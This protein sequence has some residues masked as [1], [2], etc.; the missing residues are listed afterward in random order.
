MKKKYLAF[1]CTIAC[2]FGLTACG[3]DSTLTEYEQSKVDDAKAIASETYV[4]M[5]AYYCLTNDYSSM[6]DDYTTDEIEYMFSEN[7]NLNVEGY[8]FQKAIDS[9]TSAAE[10]IGEYEGIG[11]VTAEI[12]DDQ[13]VVDV[14]VFGSEKDA[15]A[16]IIVSN[17][18]FY[19]L[20]SAALNPV[21]TMSEMMLNAALN[22]LIGMG[23]V[24]IILILISCLISAFSFI[25]KIQ[26]KL[27]AGKNEKKEQPKSGI[28]NAVAQITAQE[29][30]VSAADDL[31]I[32]AV[33]AAAVAAARGES[34][35]DGF[36]VRSIR[37][38]F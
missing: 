25:P 31:E 35:T 15:K 33:I 11:E 21:E 34:S 4:P 37:K 23:T 36:V 28:D 7:F 26:A 22:T 1:A 2:V 17:D 10:D 32:V 18:M 16:E 14:E 12:D 19:K 3:S 30:A 29:Q 13:I 8:A 9:F 27:A 20:E 6:F 24:F 5:L 38:R